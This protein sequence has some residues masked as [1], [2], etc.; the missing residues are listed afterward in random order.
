VDRLDVGAAH[1]AGARLATVAPPLLAARLVELVDALLRGD[2]ALSAHVALA[3]GP[4]ARR[5]LLA[6]FERRWKQAGSHLKI[7]SPDGS[8]AVAVAVV[9]ICFVELHQAEEG[10]DLDDRLTAAVRQMPR[11][12]RGEV[13]RLLP[14]GDYTDWWWDWVVETTSSSLTRWRRGRKG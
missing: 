14:A 4:S 8:Q 7:G 5:S 13:A 10:K 6:E 3:A 11:S 9:L 1:E 12:R 2:A